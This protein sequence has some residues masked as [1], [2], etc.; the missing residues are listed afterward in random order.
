MSISQGIVIG[1][2]AAAWPYPAVA[3]AD[4]DA[5]VT[6]RVG[7]A[8]VA[9]WRDEGSGAIRARSGGVETPVIIAYRRAWDDFY[10]D[11]GDGNGDGGA[12]SPD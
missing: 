5:P 8:A 3:A 2:D 7:G 12:G 1:D 6:G 4:A 11:D 9:L 10:G